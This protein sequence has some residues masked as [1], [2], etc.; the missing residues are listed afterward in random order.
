VQKYLNTVE[1]VFVLI[2]ESIDDNTSEKLLKGPVCQ[3][4]FKRLN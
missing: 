1:E 4:G 2:K 3:S